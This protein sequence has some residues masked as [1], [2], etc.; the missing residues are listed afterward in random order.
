MTTGFCPKCNAPLLPGAVC[1]SKCGADTGFQPQYTQ[2]QPF[3][4]QPHY[5]PQPPYTAKA[6]S[7][8]KGRI[9]LTAVISVVLTAGICVGIFG[10][11][12][13]GFFRKSKPDKAENTSASAGVTETGK[14]SKESPSVILCGVTVEVDELMLEDGERELSVTAG[15]SGQNDDGTRYESYELEM[16]DHEEF[17]VPVEVTFPCERA[18]DEYCNRFWKEVYNEDNADLLFA[19]TSAGYRKVF[20][21]ATTEQKAALTE[22]QKRT[23]WELIESDSMIKIQRFLLE[24]LQE[25]T[26]K[27]LSKITLVY[28]QEL[29]IRIQESI[30][31]ESADMAKYKGCTICLA[32]DGVKYGDLH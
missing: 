21:N 25:N 30:D 6:R 7:G 3:P 1:C 13:G 22:Q 23:V 14:V 18:V 19:A 9:A 15:E 32:S 12:N 28:N 20:F 16:G 29:T 17:Y 10:F 5:A 26:Y 2:P 11:R 8:S 24:R 31:Q 4:Q 27:E